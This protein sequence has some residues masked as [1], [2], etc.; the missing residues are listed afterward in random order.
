MCVAKFFFA[1]SWHRQ[2]APDVCLILDNVVYVCVHSFVYFACSVF[3]CSYALFRFFLRRG[4]R[5]PAG[6][7]ACSCMRKAHAP[8]LVPCILLVCEGI[9][10]V[11][12][13]TQLSV[14]LRSACGSLNDKL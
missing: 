12:A 10:S 1:V 2:Q 13:V 11:F 14:S 6:R 8:G 7:P 3:V 9:P 5:P 4:E